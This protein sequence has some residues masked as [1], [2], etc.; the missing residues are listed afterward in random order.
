MRGAREDRLDLCWPRPSTRCPE[1]VPAAPTPPSHPFFVAP[2]MTLISLQR[3]CFLSRLASVATLDCRLCALSGHQ[4]GFPL[5]RY[6]PRLHIS[7]ARLSIWT[8]QLGNYLLNSCTSGK[9]RSQPA[10]CRHCG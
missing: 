3:P 2:W 6:S 8:Q 1:S 10:L 9:T 5:P 4:S 7:R